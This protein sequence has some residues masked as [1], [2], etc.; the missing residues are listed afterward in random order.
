LSVLLKRIAEGRQNK[1]TILLRAVD[2]P[3]AKQLVA[4]SHEMLDAARSWLPGP[5][6]RLLTKMAWRLVQFRVNVDSATTLLAVIEAEIT[7]GEM[8]LTK[9]EAI[10]EV[11]AG[12]RG[13][14]T[15]ELSETLS[16]AFDKAESKA[17]WH[18]KWS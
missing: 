13:S 18:W 3:N 16:K 7:T 9:P 2:L 12:L 1:D 17:W 14:S 10:D 4:A 6:G 5:D 11:V 15:L 8:E